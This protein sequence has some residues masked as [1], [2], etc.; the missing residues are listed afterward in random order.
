MTRPF[1]LTLV[2]PAGYAHAQ[3]LAEAIEY[4]RAELTRAG[5]VAR[6]AENV[7]DPAAH[8][9]VFC[10]HLLNEDAAR[11]IPADAVLFNG[12]QLGD[13]AGWHL[14]SGVYERLLSRHYVWDYSAANLPH[15]GHDR[16]SV[17]PFAYCEDLVRRDRTRKPGEALLFYGVLTPHRQRVLAELRARDVAVEIVTAF[18]AMR[19]AW[20]FRA[21]GVLNLHKAEDRSVF[22]PVRCFYPLINGIPVLSEETTDPSAEAFRGAMAFARGVDELATLPLVDPAPF[23]QTS[24]TEGVAAAANAY[25]AHLGV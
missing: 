19:D 5:H 11:Q 4:L 16:A 21:R 17:I 8:N 10:A 2:R 1:L 3:A 9:V 6:V 22:E 20:M 13:A 15:L 24:G 25:L 23:R 14:A 12:E 18:G 7:F